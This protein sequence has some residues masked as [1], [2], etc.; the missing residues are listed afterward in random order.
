MAMKNGIYRPRGTRFFWAQYRHAGETIRESTR[1]TRLRDATAFLAERRS[2]SAQGRLVPD[3]RKATYEDLKKL[4]ADKATARGNRSRPRWKHLD[5]AF[6]GQLAVS[7]TT[8]RVL[9]YE[10]ARLA[11]G[12]ARATVNQELAAL[13]RAFNLAVEVGRLAT[14]PVVKTPDPHNA[15]QDFYTPR[16]V[17]AVYAALPAEL[18]PV[19]S[20]LFFTG[21]RI[22]EVLPLRWCENVDWKAGVVRLVPGT[23]KNREGRTFTFDVLPPLRRLLERQLAASE[24]AASA[25]V[26][27][28]AGR[29]ITYEVWNEARKRAVAAGCP[30]RWTHDLR[31]VA[32]RN[33]MRAGVATLVAMKLTGHRTQS[34][35]LRYGIVDE[36]L[37]REGVAKLAAALDP[38]PSGQ[39]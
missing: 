10:A 25:W 24:S 36:Q 21:W 38:T 35:H 7:I 5:D 19:W 1:C 2:A 16:Q 6:A 14:R 28:R 22:N 32:T 12:A 23:T 13:R 11:S 29:R 33:L 18:R 17:D 3:A 15:R 20:F 4:S 31:R 34:Q 9:A 8:A 37:L 27:H 26:F 30:D 39:E